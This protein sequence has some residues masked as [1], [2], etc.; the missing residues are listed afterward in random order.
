MASISLDQILNFIIPF[1]VWIFLL[2][3]LYTIPPI[4]EMVHRLINWFKNWRDNKEDTFVDTSVKT[5]NYE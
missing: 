1:L 4:K 3:I 2:Y 5:I